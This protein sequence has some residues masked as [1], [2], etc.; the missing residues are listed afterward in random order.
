M[1]DGIERT[2]G[3]T[4]VELTV[5][6]V[7]LVALTALSIPA[8]TRWLPNYNLKRASMDIYSS[9]LLAKSEAIRKNRPYAVFFDPG[10]ETYQFIDSGPDGIYEYPDVAADDILGETISIAKYGP[11][12]AYG[13]TP[14]TKNFDNGDATFPGDEVSYTGPDNVVLFDGRGMCN[15]GSVYLQNNNSRTFAIGTLRSGIVRIKMWQG[16]NWK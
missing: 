1:R 4:L 5:V 2:S 15:S 9:I 10:S 13:H 11:G 7:I 8:I 14:A 3:F 16:S 6:I 12:I